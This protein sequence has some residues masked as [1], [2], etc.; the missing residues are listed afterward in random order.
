MNIDYSN[1]SIEE[2]EEHSGHIL[3]LIEEKKKTR[4]SDEYMLGLE[5]LLYKFEN[6]L[7]LNFGAKNINI[8]SDRQYISIGYETNR[9]VS[10]N[11]KEKLGIWHLNQVNILSNSGLNLLFESYSHGL[12]LSINK[13]HKTTLP[14]R[15]YSTLLELEQGLTNLVRELNK[16]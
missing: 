14:N 7:V 16:Y 8:I 6:T 1:L 15:A 10:I 2:L 13:L 12:V 3:Q 4:F 11:L 5:N 9:R